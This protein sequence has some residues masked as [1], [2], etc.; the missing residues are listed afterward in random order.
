MQ[1]STEELARSQLE[2]LYR[3]GI[4]ERS[5]EDEEQ[6]QSR[7]SE[8][9]RNQRH[10]AFLAAL[11]PPSAEYPLPPRKLQAWRDNSHSSG[12]SDSIQSGDFYL[13]GRSGGGSRMLEIPR[14][15]Q[16]FKTRRS[17]SLRSSS[18]SSQSS[19]RDIRVLRLWFRQWGSFVRGRR[20][21][22]RRRARADVFL[23]QSALTRWARFLKQ[24]REEHKK[25]R[26][27]DAWKAARAISRWNQWKQ[28]CQLLRS[29][30]QGGRRSFLGRLMLQRTWRRW[31]R[32]AKRRKYVDGVLAQR[33]CCRHRRL[34][35]SVWIELRIHT[36]RA[37]QGCLARRRCFDR[38]RE[39]CATREQQRR[40]CMKLQYQALLGQKREVLHRWRAFAYA[41]SRDK[42]LVRRVRFDVRRRRYFLLWREVARTVSDVVHLR[43]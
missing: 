8:S 25:K 30:L 5:S 36:F 41:S 12:V 18:E 26:L 22:D 2:T 9:G 14:H 11:P 38:M 31:I 40:N 39:Y 4:L 6:S 35:R 33:A 1:G 3:L 16:L 43:A 28:R 10:D 7:N 34:V 20:E 42:R 21:R 37:R 32:F 23:K 13:G 24:R 29:L 19:T 17:S 15:R 27:L